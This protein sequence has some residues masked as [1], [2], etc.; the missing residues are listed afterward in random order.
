MRLYRPVGLREL[1]LIAA[2]GWR[3][4]PPRLATQPIF[5]PVLELEYARAIARDWNTKDATSGYAGFVTSFDVDDSF[6]GRY[7]V[8]TVGA[9]IHRELW[10][11]A[12][13]IESFNAAIVGGIAVLESYLGPDFAGNLPSEAPRPPGA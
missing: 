11:P 2:S 4:F 7:P 13:D 12:E 1:E 10:V 6:A 3:A 5:Y 9:A 8:Q